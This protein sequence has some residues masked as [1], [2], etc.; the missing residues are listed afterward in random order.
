MEI[1]IVK[2][3]PEL[4]IGL[5]EEGEA[6]TVEPVEYETVNVFDKF[7]EYVREIDEEGYR[8][9]KVV[10]SNKLYRMLKQ[11]DKYHQYQT[12]TYT[13]EENRPE[14][15]FGVR[16]EHEHFGVESIADFL[17]YTDRKVLHSDMLDKT[18]LEDVEVEELI[19]ETNNR[20][21]NRE[22]T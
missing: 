12:Y 8:I 14:M 22:D 3:Q 16:I 10:I 1:Q 11:H 9:R 18:F 5:N 6:G 2:N 13:E 4:N 20:V 17:I 21:E 7:R 15:L 19:H